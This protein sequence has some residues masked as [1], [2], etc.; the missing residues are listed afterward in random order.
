MHSTSCRLILQSSHLCCVVDPSY[1]TLLLKIED[2]KWVTVT[3]SCYG[4]KAIRMFSTWKVVDT[5]VL[6]SKS[7]RCMCFQIEKWPIPVFSTWKVVD[8][9]FLTRKVV[10]ACVLKMKSV[11]YVCSLLENWLIRVLTRKMADVYYIYR[12]CCP[13]RHSGFPLRWRWV[14]NMHGKAFQDALLPACDFFCGLLTSQIY[15]P[16]Y[17]YK[18]NF[19]ISRIMKAQR[20][21]WDIHPSLNLSLKWECVVDATPRPLYPREGAPV[22]FKRGWVVVR[23]CLDGCGVQKIFSLTVS[24]TLNRRTGSVIAITQTIS[25]PDYT[26]SCN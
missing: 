25:R 4:R 8:S 13:T 16:D 1:E 2:A 11:R 9:V 10:D 22:P 14:P 15:S 21:C 12:S 23:A 18:I 20:G 19:S 6:N 5:C 7:G 3:A 26:Y 24:R 17:I